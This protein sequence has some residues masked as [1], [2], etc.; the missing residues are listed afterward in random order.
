MRRSVQFISLALLILTAL[1]CF[2]QQDYV[3][4]YDAYF[5]YAYLNTSNMN[6]SQH[7]VDGEFGVNVRPWLALGGDFS[8]FEGGSNIVPSM[9]NSTQLAKLAPILPLLPPGYVLAVP[10]D[11]TTSTY[12]AGTQFNY[13]HFKALTLFARPDIGAMYQAVTLTPRDPIQAMIVQ[14][15]VGGV[16]TSDWAG[17]YGVGGGIDVN[18]SHNVGFRVMADYVHTGLFSNL[19]KNGQNTVRFSLSPTIRFGRNIMDKK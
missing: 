14:G 18:L 1:V 6:L 12:T 5:G 10:Y 8:W 9:L 17:F 11:A 3:A 15:L 7:G 2:G 4:R 19:L 16:N 13:R